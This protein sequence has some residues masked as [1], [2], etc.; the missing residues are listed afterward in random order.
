MYRLGPDVPTRFFGLCHV[1]HSNGKGVQLAL[2]LKT[3]HALARRYLASTVVAILVL[4]GAIV[5]IWAGYQSLAKDRDQLTSDRKALLEERLQSEKM[6][7]EAAIA[8]MTQKAELDKREFMLK[9]LDDQSKQQLASAQKQ[10]A[11]NEAA[12]RALQRTQ[13]SLSQ[14]QRQKEV[15]EQ[16]QALMSQ[17]SAMGVDLNEDK[18]RCSGPD[19]AAKFN[20]AKAKYAEIYTLAEAY[21]LTKRFEHFF[22]KSGQHVVSFGCGKNG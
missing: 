13:V 15:E 20:I 17:F 22:F 9:Q 1:S 6:R 11:V 4:G 8:L 2:D 14:S 5:P 10:T 19:G 12:A 21:G 3:A 7:N 18:V 16:L